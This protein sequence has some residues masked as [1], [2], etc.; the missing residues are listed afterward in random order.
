VSESSPRT[1]TSSGRLSFENPQWYLRGNRFNI[2]IRVETVQQFVGDRQFSH[3]LDIA[4]GDGSLS[5]PLLSASN[6]LTLLDVSAGMLSAAEARVPA[7]FRSRVEFINGDFLKTELPRVHFDLII[8]VGLLAHIASPQ[9]LV[10]RMVSLL[11]PGGI[12]ITEG[13]DAGHPLNR[14]LVSYRKLRSRMGGPSFVFNLLPGADVVRMFTGQGLELSTV[15]RYNLTPV[16]GAARFLPQEFLRKLIRVFYGYPWHNRNAWLGKECLYLF[17]SKR[18]PAAGGPG[19]PEKSR[20]GAES[21]F[22][23]ASP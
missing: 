21:E 6:R 1:A 15:Y 8:C 5:L 2:E 23:S 19:E 12:I 14:A 17:Q 22:A 18:S 20:H 16:P 3:I 11:R 13:T 10:E 7:E 9:A 4:C